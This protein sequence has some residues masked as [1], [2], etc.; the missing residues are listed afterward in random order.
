MKE[1]KIIK[2]ACGCGEELY[3]N[4]GHYRKRKSMSLSERLLD[5]EI[6]LLYKG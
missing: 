5:I 1:R 2:C 6:A 3:E 4:D